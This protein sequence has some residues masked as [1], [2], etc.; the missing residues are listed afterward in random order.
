MALNE[1]QVPLSNELNH[2]QAYLYLQKLRYTEDINIHIDVDSEL[3]HCKTVKLILQPLIENSI[4]HAR[5]ENGN[6]L[7]ITLY[8]YYDDEFYYLVIE[9]DGV[10]VAPEVIESILNGNE[11]QCAS[12]YGLKNVIGRI[13]MCS[14][15]LGSVSIESEYGICTKITIRQLR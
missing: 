13:R 6:S 1:N 4:Y 11:N 15:G 10:G 7:N 5:R 14:H 8:S 12:G 2:L 9:D 3:L